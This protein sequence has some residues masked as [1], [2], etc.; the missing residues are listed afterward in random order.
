MKKEQFK[1]K[2]DHKFTD[3]LKVLI[4]SFLMV[5]PFFSILSRCMYVVFN[6]NAKYSYYGETIN[7]RTNTLLTNKNQFEL[8]QTYTFNSNT[9]DIKDIDSATGAYAYVINV[10]NV[11]ILE[12]SL[13]DLINFNRFSLYITSGL[14]LSIQLA[15]SDT[16][17]IKYF[18]ASNF[19][20]FSFDYEGNNLLFDFTYNDLFYKTTFNNYSFLD[21]AF[22][23][24]CD[25]LK[26]SPVFSWTQDTATYD[27]FNTMLTGLT[28]QDGILPILLTYWMMLIVVYVIVDIIIKT[29]TFITHIIN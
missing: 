29:F 27:V 16:T 28:I 22:D 9:F 15:N 13:Q 2:H 10:S 8:N 20:I 11:K 18:T 17:Q 1:N 26:T 21:N 4:F 6:P 19:L 14:Q 5:A 23:Y 7:D 3:I 12:T 25:Q 24:S